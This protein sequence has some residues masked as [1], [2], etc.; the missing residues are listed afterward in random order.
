MAFDPNEVDFTIPTTGSRIIWDHVDDG[1]KFFLGNNNSRPL[2]VDK[3]GT[4]L[5]ALGG[6]AGST[7]L[8]TGAAGAPSA[9]EPSCG[10]VNA[11]N[12]AVCKGQIYRTG[13]FFNIDMRNGGSPNA[14]PHLEQDIW[15]PINVQ[16]L[17]SPYAPQSPRQA[18]TYTLNKNPG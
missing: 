5:G 16:R 10:F 14:D 15:A 6:G 12:G 9:V 17:T 18:I 11:F 1:A 7:L 13:S 4:L 2:F 3:D 8:G